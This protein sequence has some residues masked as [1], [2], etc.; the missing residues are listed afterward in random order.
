MKSW[1]QDMYST[2]NEGK[3]AVTVKFIRILKKNKLQIYNF[4][5]K[6]YVY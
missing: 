2:H 3:P 1:L 6:K 5:I 4:N